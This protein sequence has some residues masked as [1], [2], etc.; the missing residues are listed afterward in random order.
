MVLLWS[1]HNLKHT[2]YSMGVCLHF[3]LDQQAPG[4][5][6]LIHPHLTLKIPILPQNQFGNRFGRPLILLAFYHFPD[7]KKIKITPQNH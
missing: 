7:L 5:G 3:G 2:V 1:I 4:A 6:Y